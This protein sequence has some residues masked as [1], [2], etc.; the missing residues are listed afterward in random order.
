[1]ANMP[2]LIAGLAVSLLLSACASSPAAPRT[3]TG[4]APRSSIVVVPEVMSG[5]GLDGVIGE[6]AASLT[7]RLGEP[8]IDLAE[9]DVRKLQF[10]GQSCVLDVY[11]YP[12]SAGAE[13]VAT[14]IEARLRE[15]GA[16]IDRAQCLREVERR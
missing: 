9:G 14:H 4:P 10:A 7:R 13:P 5:W 3:A 8:R 1:M 6:R 15:G 12:M 16:P 2:A 11:L